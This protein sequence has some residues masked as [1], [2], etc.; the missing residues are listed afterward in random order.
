MNC[1]IQENIESNFFFSHFKSLIQL[2]MVPSEFSKV[3]WSPVDHTALAIVKLFDKVGASN[4]THHIFNP[5]TCDLF[6]LLNNSHGFKLKKVHISEFIREVLVR[7][8]ADD[9]T[10]THHLLSLYQL[11]VN[12]IHG[13][14]NTKIRLLQ[15][16]TQYLLA[17]LGFSWSKILPRHLSSFVEKSL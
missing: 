6:E 15:D 9:V 1:R 14:Y 7:F 3:E 11:W 17:N 16:K 2:Q 13:T 8:D 4:Q 10:K 5:Y 12:E